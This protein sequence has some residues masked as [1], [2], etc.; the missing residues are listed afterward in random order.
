MCHRVRNKLNV[1][2]IHKDIVVSGCLIE[3][4]FVIRVRADSY[5]CWCGTWNIILGE[6]KVPMNFL[7]AGTVINA[8][9]Y[10]NPAAGGHSH[11][12]LMLV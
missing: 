2:L 12:P 5:L 11:M 7:T 4:V 10:L 1:S 6:D 3:R 8:K 9:G